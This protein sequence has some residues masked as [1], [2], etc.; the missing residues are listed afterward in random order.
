MSA[1]RLWQDLGFWSF[2]VFILLSA[3]RAAAR[4]AD[5]ASRW[6]TEI[7]RGRRPL[8][9]SPIAWALRQIVDKEETT[10]ST[11]AVIESSSAGCCG[12]IAPD[13]TIVNNQKSIAEPEFSGD[14]AFGRRRI[15]FSSAVCIPRSKIWTSETL[16]LVTAQDWVD[17]PAVLLLPDWRLLLA[18][19]SVLIGLFNPYF[20]E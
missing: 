18:S 12:I 9:P 3:K 1:D 15:F 13:S 10:Q 17:Q 7:P 16:F 14:H 6:S 2:P 11:L 5:D 20:C 4:N 19:R 8:A